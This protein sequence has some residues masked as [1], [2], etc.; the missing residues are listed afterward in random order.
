MKMNS[1]ESASIRLVMQQPA[2]PKYRLPVF[3]E[4]SRRPGVKLYIDYGDMPGIPN[5]EPAGLDARQSHLCVGHL[6]RHPIYW[7]SAQYRYIKHSTTDVLLLSWNLHYATLIPALLL[8]K[9]RGIP[10]ILWGHGCSK[11]ESRLRKFSRST[12]ARLATALLFYNQ[13]VADEYLRDGWNPQRIYVAPNA[14]DQQAIQAAREHWL[15]RPDE[16]RSFQKEKGLDTG[17]VVVF[18]SRFDPANQVDLLLKAVASLTSQFPDLKLAVVG[19]G[20]PEGR[21]LRELAES[22]GLKDRVLFPG[23]IYEEMQLAPWFLS[24]KL[25]CYPSNMGLSLLHAFGYGLPVVTCDSV[26]AHGP[27]FFALRPGENG[28][29]FPPG[30]DQALAQ[31]IRSILIDPNLQQRLSQQAHRTVTEQYSVK[32]MVDGMVA[33]VQYCVQQ[34]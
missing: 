21:R 13:T 5:V 33:A 34:R 3:Q 29:L 19:K 25:F 24:A 32:Q 9:L 20:E 18:V 12:V 23:A 1:D 4:L 2:F 27:E 6:G 17:P 22:L 30:D 8:A 11:T 7:H 26:S 14:L 16:L 15:S 10:T 28:L 31:A